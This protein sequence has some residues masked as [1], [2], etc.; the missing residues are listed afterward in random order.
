M[1]WDTYE[2]IGIFGIVFWESDETKRLT[3]KCQVPESAKHQVTG[4]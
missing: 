4:Q 3:I 2:K 1:T